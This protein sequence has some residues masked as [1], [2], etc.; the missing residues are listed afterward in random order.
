MWIFMQF[1]CTFSSMLTF[2]IF[3]K[4]IKVALLHVLQK[5]PRTAGLQNSARLQGFYMNEQDKG[6]SETVRSIIWSMH[7]STGKQKLSTDR[8]GEQGNN[9]RKYASKLWSMWSSCEKI[10]E[11]ILI[12][13]NYPVPTIT[14]NSSTRNDTSPHCR[15]TLYNKQKTSSLRKLI[16]HVDQRWPLK[17]KA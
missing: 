2:N 8:E 7:R 10:P 12:F 11:E 13:Q 6:F 14:F 17:V 4:K 1:L 15:H 16:C 5:L 3:L 9:G